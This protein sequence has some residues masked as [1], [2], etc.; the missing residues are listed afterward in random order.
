MPNEL[1]YS[2]DSDLTFTVWYENKII[3]K[4]DPLNDDVRQVYVYENGE[5]IFK[6]TFL[7]PEDAYSFFCTLVG[8]SN[9]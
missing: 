1:E 4:V 5:Y 9:D 8:A 6:H 3:G 7:F 2:V